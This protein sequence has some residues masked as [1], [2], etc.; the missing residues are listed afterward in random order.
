VLV[1]LP[2]FTRLVIGNFVR[3]VSNFLSTIIPL[4]RKLSYPVV[5]L[6]VCCL[7]TVLLLLNSVYSHNATMKLVITLEIV[8]LQ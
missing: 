5:L 8:M 1:K 6:L 4:K 2:L 3:Q 7:L